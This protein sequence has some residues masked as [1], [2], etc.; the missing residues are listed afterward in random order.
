MSVSDKTGLVEL[1]RGLAALGVEL[2]S[3][4]G[5][6]TALAAAGLPVVGVSDVLD[7]VA[8]CT[9]AGLVG[10]IDN[11]AGRVDLD[12]FLRPRAWQAG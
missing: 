4:G 3:T 8:E 5:T 7:V 12:E 6:A 2:V 9:F 10:M 1:G 11:L